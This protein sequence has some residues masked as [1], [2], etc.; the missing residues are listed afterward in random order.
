MFAN[1]GNYIIM[2]Y[3]GSIE[4]KQSRIKL[5]D[6]GQLVSCD[7][8][9]EIETWLSPRNFFQGGKS[10]VMQISVVI[11]LFSDQISGRG[12]SFQGGQTASGGRPLPPCGRKPET[13]QAELVLYLQ[14]VCLS[15]PLQ[16]AAPGNEV[17]NLLFMYDMEQLLR[18]N[19]IIYSN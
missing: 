6:L 12:K 3:N 18:S 15:L 11:L 7:T 14:S 2:E 10:I 5:T 19:K 16:P 1:G 4:T 9:G 13:V 17:S 8:V